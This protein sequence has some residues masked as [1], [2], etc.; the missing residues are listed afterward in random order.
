MGGERMIP[1]QRMLDRHPDRVIRL[2][3]KGMLPKNALG[4]Q[5]LSKLKVYPGAEHPHAAQVPQE[6][7]F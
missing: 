5:M 3:V 2:A 4:R 7:E 1:F 6:L